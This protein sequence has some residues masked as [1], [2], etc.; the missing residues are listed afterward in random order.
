MKKQIPNLI[1]LSNL[2]CGVIATY[3]AIQGQLHIAALFICLGI[4][5]DFF[6]GLTARLLNV[7]SS[8][9]KELDSLADVITSGVAPAFILFNILQASTI[10]WLPF[11]AFLMPAFSAYRLGKFNIDTRQSHSFRGLPVPATALIW[12]SI[13]ICY[14]YPQITHIAL[15]PLNDIHLWLFSQIGLIIIAIASI[16]FDII[17]ISDIPMFALKFK[18]LHWNE[19]KLRFIFLITSLILLILF[20][21]FGLALVILYYICLSIFTQKSIKNE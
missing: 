18:N 13:G 16:L 2:T 12:A 11:V 15:L 21:I 10:H 14:S 7:A 1:T 19:N 5:F 4:F 8:L 17:M 3:F 20:G 9:G 6:D